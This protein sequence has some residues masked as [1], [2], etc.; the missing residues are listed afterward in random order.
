MDPVQG[1]VIVVVMFSVHPPDLGKPVGVCLCS[2]VQRIWGGKSPAIDTS[3]AQ[4]TRD[5]KLPKKKFISR[6]FKYLK[7]YHWQVRGNAPIEK[8]LANLKEEFV[9]ILMGL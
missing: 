9:S 5:I 6:I 1:Y 7:L 3:S 4:K 8:V 2:M